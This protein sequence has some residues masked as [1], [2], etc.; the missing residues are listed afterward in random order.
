MG[1]VA[2]SQRFESG[3]AW[4]PG[5]ARG[6]Y[7]RGSYTGTVSVFRVGAGAAR[8]VIQRRTASTV[9]RTVSA[10][11]VVARKQRSF[12]RKTLSGGVAGISFTHQPW[13]LITPAVITVHS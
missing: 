10:S 2:V 5:A 6:A 4:H 8:I 12:R 7:V 13:T 1:D 9:I 3:G 11:I